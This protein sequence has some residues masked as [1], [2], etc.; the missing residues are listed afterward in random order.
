MSKLP[1]S[2]SS[3]TSDSKSSSNSQKIANKEES[4]DATANSNELGTFA[5]LQQQMSGVKISSLDYSYSDG[6]M[7]VY[8]SEDVTAQCELYSFPIVI[9]MK[10]L[11]TSNN[12]NAAS[13]DGGVNYKNYVQFY[14]KNLA[15]QARYL[16]ENEENQNESNQSQTD[17]DEKQETTKDKHNINK[18][19]CD[20]I[21]Q[22]LKESLDASGNK[23]AFVNG[24]IN[25]NRKFMSQ[26]DGTI[27]D[28]EIAWMLN[29][30][31]IDGY[32]NTHWVTK[33]DGLKDFLQK[34][35]TLLGNVCIVGDMSE[36]RD[37]RDTWTKG[38]VMVFGTEMKNNQIVVFLMDKVLHAATNI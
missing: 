34:F 38:R 8:R 20:V 1:S 36:N 37:G 27:S 29:N 30:F 19:K 9:K 35:E 23:E 18:I 28:T 33:I 5:T 24:L 32:K 14:I 17:S 26:F 3:Q 7:G 10:P 4:Q 16:T 31:K 25:Q 6:V 15:K 13:A 11:K 21:A 12:S 22:Y 2:S